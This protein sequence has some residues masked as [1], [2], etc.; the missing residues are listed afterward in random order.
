MVM[1]LSSY[2]ALL[3]RSWRHT[4]HHTT[5]KFSLV[6]VVESTNRFS[7]P[8]T[9]NSYSKSNTS[10]L[11]GLLLTYII[12]EEDAF[13]AL[14][15]L[16]TGPRHRLHGIFVSGFPGLQRLFT[17]HER[18]IKRLLPSIHKHFT[19]QQMVTS[20]YAL[21][22]FMQCFLDRVSPLTCVCVCV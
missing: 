11:V 14:S 16:M 9:R 10:E 15:Q 21:K 20:T 4:N 12:E 5:S 18:V 1:M 7:Q 3:A 19:Q 13:W 2:P 6:V 22:W 8:Q 17:H